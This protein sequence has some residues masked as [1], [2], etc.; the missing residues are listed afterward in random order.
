MLSLI[1]DKDPEFRATYDI[2]FIR[3]AMEL[4][5]QEEICQI[6]QSVTKELTEFDS[7]FIGGFGWMDTEIIYNKGVPAVAYGPKGFGAHAA[8]EY[9]DLNSVILASKVQEKVIKR[10]CVVS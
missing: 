9:V 2:T 10:F 3:D 7:K 8:E 5:P 1:A 4:D 6:L